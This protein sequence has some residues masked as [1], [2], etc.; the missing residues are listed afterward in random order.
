MRLLW[1]LPV[2]AAFFM[3]DAVTYDVTANTSS[4]TGTMGSLDFITSGGTFDFSMFSDAA[5]PN[6]LSTING[7]EICES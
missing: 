2:C 5:G 4:I 6:S 1:L 7:E 3:A